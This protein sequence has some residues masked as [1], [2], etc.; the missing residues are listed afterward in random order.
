MRLNP[1]LSG[2]LTNHEQNNRLKSIN[3]DNKVNTAQIKKSCHCERSAAILLTDPNIHLDCRAA[4]A[5]TKV[6]V[7]KGISINLRI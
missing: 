3:C 4:L 7:M 6:I 2:F 1:L 5:M